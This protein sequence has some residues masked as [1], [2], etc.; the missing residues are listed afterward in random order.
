MKILTGFKTILRIN[1]ILSNSYRIKSCSPSTN[2]K[3]YNVNAPLFKS[4]ITPELILIK[5]LFSK[6]GY[7]LRIAGG[8][9][10]DLLM[11]IQPHDVDLATNAVPDQ[12]LYMFKKENI[13]IFNLNGIK[14]GTVTIRIN[15]KVN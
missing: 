7:E 1:K 6:Y 9:V 5:E 13:R 15:E 2:L 12:M 4:I 10:R 11:E 14:H 8:A 3:T